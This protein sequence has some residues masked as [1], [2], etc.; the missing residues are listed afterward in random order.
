MILSFI[1]VCCGKSF[2]DVK[3]SQQQRVPTTIADF[4]GLLDNKVMMNQNSPCLIGMV[5]GDEF[6]IKSEAWQSFPNEIAYHNFYKNAYF[7]E[8]QIYE[9]G[10]LYTDWSRGYMDILQANIVLDGLKSIRPFD[11]ESESWNI[12]YGGALFQRALRYDNLA[13][14]YC[15]TYDSSKAN[16]EL[17]LP[18]RLEADITL[19]V[20]RSSLYETY[21]QIIADLQQAFDLLPD[22]TENKFRASK[23]AAL[24]LL[25]RI[26]LQIGDYENALKY[27]EKTLSY[28]T[29]LIDFNSIDLTANY[30]F[31]PFAK[32]NPEVIF[33]DLRYTDSE[34][35]SNF[36]IYFNVDTLLLASYLTG[37]LRKSANFFITDNYR[38]LYKGSY[39][40]DM[41]FFVGLATDEIFLISAEC[42][43]RLG[44]DL[45]AINDLNLLLEN[46][47]KKESFVPLV[48]ETESDIMDLILE[49]RKKELVFRGLRWE[50]LKRLNKEIKYFTTLKRRLF[51][52]D[53]FLTPGDPKWVYPIPPEALI[54][55]NY[56]Q[57]ER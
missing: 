29:Q 13:Q 28:T 15:K 53:Y 10:E 42:N 26:Y 20:P 5:S 44:N 40:G 11:D 56:E 17:G 24:A 7:W 52:V 55:G 33:I 6:Y 9:G 1:M 18:L 27:S 14:L 49:E 16:E 35:L 37:D 31:L 21:Q 12:A 36:D 23:V 38:N 2:L 8:K 54:S 39:G 19:K 50:D 43:A 22:Y 4:Q 41:G 45:A 3:P 51:E 48:S 30:S 47:M 25:A 34:L 57:N 32:D 46:R